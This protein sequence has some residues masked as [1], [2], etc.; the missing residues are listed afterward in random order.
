LERVGDIVVDAQAQRFQAFVPI[1]Y[2]RDDYDWH[3]PCAALY[4]AENVPK[5][6]VGQTL[7]AE[8]QRDRTANQGC[9]GFLRRGG[10]DWLDAMAAKD[11]GKRPAN[12]RVG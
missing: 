5:A 3:N 2:A 6:A 9:L 10:K 11:V 12:L 1:T 8:D 4:F 7:F